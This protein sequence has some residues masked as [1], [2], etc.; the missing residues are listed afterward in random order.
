MPGGIDI[1]VCGGREPAGGLDDHRSAAH[2]MVDT[3]AEH[4]RSDE[5]CL[6]G[7]LGGEVVEEEA[8]AGEESFEAF[9]DT[10]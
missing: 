7:G 5:E 4:G 9:D 1:D 3:I 6:L 10:A 2:R 8:F